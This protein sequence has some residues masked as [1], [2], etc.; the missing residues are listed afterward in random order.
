MVEKALGMDKWRKV[1]M[2]K[3]E[4]SKFNRMKRKGSLIY[5]GFQNTTICGDILGSR[6][7]MWANFIMIYGLLHAFNV[8]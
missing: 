8:Y 3:V 1:A 2:A 5:Y 7:M 4:G 6:K